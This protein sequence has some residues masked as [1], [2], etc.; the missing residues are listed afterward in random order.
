MEIS[1]EEAIAKI[2]EHIKACKEKRDLYVK[3]NMGYSEADIQGRK[4]GLQIALEIVKQIMEPTIMNM[5]EELVRKSN[6]R[7]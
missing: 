2:E 6:G 4:D 5:N 7:N 1:K 3:E